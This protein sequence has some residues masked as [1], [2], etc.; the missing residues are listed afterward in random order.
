MRKP[1]LSLFLGAVASIPMIFLLVWARSG[2]LNPQNPEDG[3]SLMLRTGVASLLAGVLFP[4]M[5]RLKRPQ[6]FCRESLQR[7]M[8]DCFMGLA[9][10][11]G[12]ACLFL[13][14]A[15][16]AWGQTPTYSHSQIICEFVSV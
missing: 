8:T 11:F 3:V 6:G 13:W 9:F 15:V 10:L 7:N 5:S 4:Y 14:L 2:G 1:F 12:V 16:S